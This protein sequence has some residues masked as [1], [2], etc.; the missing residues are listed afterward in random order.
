MLTIYIPVTANILYS[1]IVALG[2][3]TMKI[4]YRK[5]GVT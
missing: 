1:H 3:Q 4:G 2:Q 5:G